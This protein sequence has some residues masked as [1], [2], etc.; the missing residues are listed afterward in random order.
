VAITINV[1][2]ES[3]NYPQ[4]GDTNW[5]DEATDFAVQTASAFG[6]IGLASGTTVDLPGTLDVTGATTLD[7]TLTVAGTTTLNGNVNLGNAIGDTT[8]ISGNTTIGGTLGVTGNATIPEV[9]LDNVQATGSAGVTIENN[10]STDVAIFGAGGGTGTSLLG[11]LNVNGNTTLGDASGD[12]TTINGTAVSVPNGLNIDS[13]T[14]VIDAANN[15]VG[16]GTSSPIIGLDVN[17]NARIGTT[18]DWTGL[19][20]ISKSDSSS[21]AKTSFL[22]SSNNLGITDSHIFFVHNPDGSS[23]ISLATTP[24]GSRSSDRRVT[25]FN[26]AGDGQLSAVV[27]GGSTLYPGFLCRAWV[28]FDGTTSPGTI[29]SHGNINSITR[30]ATGDYTISFINNMPDINYSYNVSNSS[31]YG[32]AYTGAVSINTIESS[33]SESAPTVSSFR[34]CIRNSSNV[35]YNPKYLNVSVFR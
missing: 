35:A 23:T 11:G 32:V 20:I 9:V 6:K 14:F 27:P 30:N 25:R 2:G 24:S 12:T 33:T 22:D 26:V 1:N 5:S 28:N 4:T 16:I 7:S 13:N 29:R 3:I 21:V 10:S 18:G 34:F 17:D 8:A 31:N 15:R 19:K